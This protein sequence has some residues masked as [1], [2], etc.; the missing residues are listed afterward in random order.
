MIAQDRQSSVEQSPIEATGHIRR[1]SL[2]REGVWKGSMVPVFGSIANAIDDAIG[3]RMT[4]LPITPARV[5]AALREGEGRDVSLQ[6]GARHLYKEILEAP[7]RLTCRHSG[8]V[9]SRLI[10]HL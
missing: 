3:L 10:E 7:H 5:L 8:K 1:R 2:R 6:S 9:G 4:E